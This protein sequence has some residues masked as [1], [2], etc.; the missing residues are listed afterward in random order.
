M[1]VE[2]L[3]ELDELLAFIQNEAT[4]ELQNLPPEDQG[5]AGKLFV[6]QQARDALHA[7]VNGESQQNNQRNQ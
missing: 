2:Q 5:S 7:I 3:T 1:P 6:A 4:F